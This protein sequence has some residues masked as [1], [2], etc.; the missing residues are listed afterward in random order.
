MITANSP[1]V[2]RG[3]APPR[4]PHPMGSINSSDLPRISS[5]L[6]RGPPIGTEHMN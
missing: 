3:A 6:R 5:Y 4:L 2:R 1:F